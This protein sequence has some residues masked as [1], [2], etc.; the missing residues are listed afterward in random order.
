MKTWLLFLCGLSVFPA[1]AGSTDWV[2]SADST[3]EFVRIQ[4]AIDVADHGDRILIQAGTYVER[5]NLL[6]K[7]LELIGEEGPDQTIVD[8][9]KKSDISQNPFE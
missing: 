4:D 3:A 8:E 9:I 5:L 6:G 2:V 7:S 1:V